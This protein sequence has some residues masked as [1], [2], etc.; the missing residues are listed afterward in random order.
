MSIRHVFPLFLAVLAAPVSAQAPGCGSLRLDEREHVL[1]PAS[2]GVNGT[3]AGP[4]NSLMLWT[5]EGGLFRLEPGRAVERVSIPPGVWISGVA[6]VPGTAVIRILDG[7]ARSE[8]W[9]G[10]DGR[11]LGRNAVAIPGSEVVDQA[12]PV[13]GR[14]VT[15]A[16][17]VS[18]R[19]FVVRRYD[20]GDSSV[21]L[22]RS[23]PADSV[24]AI[25]RYTITPGVGDLLVSARL[26][27]FA[28]SRVAMDGSTAAGLE[29]PLAG[30]RS[31][32]IPPDSLRFWRSLGALPLDCGTVQ[33]LSDLTSTRRLLV[34]YDAA[35]RVAAVAA[36]DA[37]VGLV[38]SRP[39]R[40]EM[41]AARRAGG[42]ELVLYDWR[43]V[44]PDPVT[45]PSRD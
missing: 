44:R 45:S 24:A 14:W 28:V 16:R 40:Q 29:L 43:W 36:L 2:L 37:P 42:L 1:L 17:D 33:T 19:V 11:I 10:A 41:I 7:G 6:A 23:A 35:G 20:A 22:F 21:V 38:Q 9:V 32:L 5:A 30:D 4:G 13:G 12:V 3:V 26:A 31:S 8:V 39:E 25:P 27:P 18:A 34:R 15:A